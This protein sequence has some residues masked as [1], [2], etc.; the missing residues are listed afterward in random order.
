MTRLVPSRNARPNRKSSWFNRSP[1]IVPG[2]TRFTD[3]FAA[4][5][6]RGRP[7]DGAI[8][9]LVAVKVAAISGPGTFWNVPLTCTP[10]TGSVYDPSTLNWVAGCSVRQ[11]GFTAA[12]SGNC[13]RI[14][15][16]S[17]VSVPLS[18]PPCR[19]RPLSNRALTPTATPFHIW[20]W[21][22]KRLA[23]VVMLSV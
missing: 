13:A 8:S 10:T 5:P 12:I 11:Y 18:M 22:P 20:T 21:S 3:T 19:S 9:A 1:Y 7:S 16:V 6:E 14:S 15:Q 2:S 23:N 17:F 4:P